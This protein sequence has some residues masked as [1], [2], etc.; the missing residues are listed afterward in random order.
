VRFQFARQT[1]DPKNILA[2]ASISTGCALYFL[3]K[4]PTSLG[5]IRW[6]SSNCNPIGAKDP[7]Y[8]HFYFFCVTFAWYSKPFNCNRLETLQ[9]VSLRRSEFLPLL[10]NQIALY[11]F[12]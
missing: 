1:L 6:V 11:L 9:F 5:A 4:T 3:A 7:R 2:S 12:G 8:A 10:A